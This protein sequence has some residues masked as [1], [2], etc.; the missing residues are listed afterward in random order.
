MFR[1]YDRGCMAEKVFSTT[2]RSLRLGRG[3][4]QQELADRARLSVRTVSDLERGKKTMPRLATVRLLAQAL[5]ALPEESSALL[6][7][8]NPSLS[9]NN[10]ELDDLAARSGAFLKISYATRADGAATAYGSVG[11][12][13]VLLIPP[14]L[15]SHLEWWGTDPG[16][17]PW[18]RTLADHRTL[19]LYDR[20]GCGLSDRNRTNFTAE[21]DMQ[22]I[23]AVAAAVGGDPIDVYGDSWGSQP[24]VLFAVRHPERVRRLV[25]HAPSLG[26]SDLRPSAP[27]MGTPT[28]TRRFVLERRAA[29][30]ALRRADLE[31]YVRSA[32]MLMFPSGLDAEAFASFVRLF[33]MAATIEMQEGL[34]TVEFELE[35]LLDKVRIPTL[36]VHRRGDRA[37]PFSVGKYV[38]SRIPGAQF[39]PLEGDAH[40]PWIG[41]WQSMSRAFLD[42]LLEA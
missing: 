14:G 39:V 42:F 27:E 34:D 9:P 10:A 28:D 18:L 31:L 13:P 11:Q 30:S 8:A 3:Y 33:R 36:I 4:T 25:L 12:G 24:A 20:H 1:E 15:I 32:V 23:D 7:A 6:K 29:L 5:N 17:G 37:C 40:F 21:D 19:V 38:A 2:L 41:D 35:P 22:D 26:G 16:V